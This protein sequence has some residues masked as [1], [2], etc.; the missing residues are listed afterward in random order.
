MMGRFRGCFP[1]LLTISAAAL[2]ACSEGGGGVGP[3]EQGA[4][5]ISLDITSDR[6]L[7]P[8]TVYTLGGFVHVTQGAT[9][10][11]L[12][13]TRIEGRSG[14]ALFILRG[15]KIDARGTATSPIVF[16]SAQPEGQRSPGDWGGLIIVGNGIVNRASPV[17][18][19]GTNTNP[20]GGSGQN[21]AVDYSGGSNN[22][23]DSGVLEYVRIEFAGFGPAQDAELNSITLAAVGSGT[24]I[25][26]VQ[27]LAG[28]DDSFEW[29][30]G[31]VDGKY[32][33]SYESGDDHF[34]ASEGY[35]G[36]NQFLIAYQSTQLQNAPGAGNTSSD[37]QGFENDG[38]AGA[39]CNSGQTSQ[40]YTIPMFA[41]FSVIGPGPGVYTAPGGGRGMVL[42]RGTGG[43]YVNGIVARWPSAAIA[44]RDAAT[45]SRIEAGDFTLRNILVAENGTMFEPDVASSSTRHFALDATVNQIVAH[46]GTA[47][48]LFTGLPSQPAVPTT[49]TLDWALAANSPA[50][51]GGTGPFTGALAA[52]AGNFVT[53]TSYRGAADPNGQRWW[54]GWTSYA[55]R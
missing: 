55:R 1:A 51:T 10:R 30:G 16:T 27:T 31:A 36:R 32:L 49:A 15:A 38:C 2:A 25:Q 35:V 45:Q 22:A 19:E 12:P 41:N 5:T 47:T 34:D 37:P 23:D 21:Y 48:S 40:P 26:Y 52:K 4:A 13:G 29:F 24:R 28:L 53:G 11:I 20:G 7:S 6:T 54:T 17:L 14:S 46:S 9:L 33:I 39:N 44:I 8:D 3:V 43:H 50:R 18:L 42:R